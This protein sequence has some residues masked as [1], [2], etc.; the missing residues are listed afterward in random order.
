MNETRFSYH[1]FLNNVRVSRPF[2]DGVE[3]YDLLL[4]GDHKIG[5]LAF[6]GAV[7]HARKPE[8]WGTKLEAG[9]RLAEERDSMLTS[10]PSLSSQHNMPAPHAIRVRSV[11]L[12]RD[13]LQVAL[14]QVARS[15]GRRSDLD[16][17]Q[18]HREWGM[19]MKWKRRDW[20]H[21][22]PFQGLEK[23]QWAVC[24]A[25][26]LRTYGMRMRGTGQGVSRQLRTR[27]CMSRGKGLTLSQQEINLSIQMDYL[28]TLGSAAVS[29]IVQKSGLN[30]PFSL[31]KRFPPLD[32]SSIWT[33]YD[34]TKR[35]M[36]F[37]HRACSPVLTQTQ[38]DGT[39]VSVFEFSSQQKRNLLPVAQNAVKKLRVTRHPD[40]LKFMDTVEADG[41]IYVMTERVKPLSSS[42]EVSSVKQDK[43][44]W[45][46][47]GLHRITVRASSLI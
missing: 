26:C 21:L 18:G 3:L 41:T 16:L 28:R 15:V 34:A 7:R 43:Q 44:D 47:W 9:K 37:F 30:L 40:I 1:A 17:G 2:R 38:D 24:R 32:T 20:T 5:Q 33:L 12:D 13:L 39:P 8:T 27:P 36:S 46:L 19:S 23:V 31:G 14:L 22:G 4:P 29:T 25:S 10:L 11:V 45:I 35:V 42:W 6:S